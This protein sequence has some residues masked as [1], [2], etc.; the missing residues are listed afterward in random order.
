MKRL[1]YIVAGL[2]VALAVFQLFLRYEYLKAGYEWYR[3]DRVTAQSCVMPCK[4]KDRSTDIVA[5]RTEPTTSTEDAWETSGNQLFADN[6]ASCH[7]A[8]GAGGGVGPSLL[9]ES[10]RKT[11]MGVVAWIKYPQP[12]M[13]KLYP[14][15]LTERDV[16]HLASYVSSL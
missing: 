12:P 1:P 8:G 2:I 5:D 13:P 16:E 11:H 7:G 3:I 4:E 10:A 15:P 6:C 9:G 14:S